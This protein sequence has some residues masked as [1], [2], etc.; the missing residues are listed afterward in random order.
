MVAQSLR[1]ADCICWKGVVIWTSP[2][3]CWLEMWEPSDY[4]CPQLALWVISA[5]SKS[6]WVRDSFGP[7][8]WRVKSALR[9]HSMS[10]RAASSPGHWGTKALPAASQHPSDVHLMGSSIACMASSCYVVHWLK[11]AVCISPRAPESL[12]SRRACSCAADSTPRTDVD[13]EIVYVLR[14]SFRLCLW[15]MAALLVLLKS[16]TL[17]HA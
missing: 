15:Y 10:D 7:G 12:D 13:Q 1:E 6:E 2:C 16:P 17:W 8:L 11:G 3:G 5:H 9:V 4:P 14:A